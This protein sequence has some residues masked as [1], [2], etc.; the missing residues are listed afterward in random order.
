MANEPVQN[1]CPD[2]PDGAAGICGSNPVGDASASRGSNLPSS[3]P[4]P[5]DAR[6]SAGASAS[7][8]PDAPGGAPPAHVGPID[9]IDP[10]GE[11]GH[12]VYGDALFRKKRRR[13]HRVVARPALEGPVADSHTH[14]D[15]LSDPALALA[16]CAVGRVDFICTVCDPSEDARRTY[17]SLPLWRSEALRRLPDVFAATRR[18]IERAR[19]EAASDPQALGVEA[20][21]GSDDLS[22]DEAASQ[23]CPCDVAVP[24]VRVACGVHPHNAHAWSASLETELLR[25]LARPETSV[26]GEAGLDYYY[27]LS[28]RDMQREVF[29]RQ[30]EIARIAGLPLMLH[31]RDAA[32][33]GRHERSAHEDAFDI[34][35]STGWPAAG[36]LIHCCSVGPD[37]LGP[38]IERGAFAAFGGALTFKNADA[39]RASCAIVP[40]GRLLF[41]TDAPYMTPVPFRGQ[42][43]GP[44][45]IV[46]TAHRAAAVVGADSG[47]SRARFLSEVHETTLGFEDR[48]PTSWQLSQGANHA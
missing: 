47:A 46:F 10:E 24:R 18:S 12:L 1:A 39:I 32:Q 36:V 23:R 33:T 15:M 44:D 34:I 2:A 42:E 25:L 3:A 14:L 37:E 6:S 28:P 38:W 8:G 4:E 26:L 27:D 21:P 31:L 19:Q 11:A 30:V 5:C 45:H 41:E 13:G 29:R 43:N 35:E 7:C 20:I 48:G 16:R 17:E 40:R 22:A 9:P